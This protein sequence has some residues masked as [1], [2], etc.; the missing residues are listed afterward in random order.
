MLES[1]AAS[2]AQWEEGIAALPAM[3][4]WQKEAFGEELMK[5]VN[6]PEITA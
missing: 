1:V 3:K 5:L 6:D 2:A 4:Q